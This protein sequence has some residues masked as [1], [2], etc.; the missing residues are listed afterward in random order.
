[1]IYVV[2]VWEAVTGI[3]LAYLPVK[4]ANVLFIDVCDQAALRLP[5]MQ[6]QKLLILRCCSF[7]TWGRDRVAFF[8]AYKGCQYFD[9][10]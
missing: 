10:V 9:D 3:S 8:F 2:T 6:D 7:S 4:A 5:K 1:M